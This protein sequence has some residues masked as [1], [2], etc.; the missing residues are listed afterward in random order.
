MSVALLDPDLFQAAGAVIVLL[1]GV[2]VAAACVERLRRDRH[3]AA[4]R[5]VDREQF[6]RRLEVETRA[7]QGRHE[8][9]AERATWEG[10]REFVVSRIA[11]HENPCGSV[12]SF[13]LESRDARPLP[14]FRPGQFLTLRLHVPGESRPVVRCYSLSEGPGAERFRFTV[15]RM[16]GGRASGFLHDQVHEGHVLEVKAPGGGFCI[17]TSEGHPLVLLAGGVGLTPLLS[18]L[19]ALERCGS[20]REAWL[21]YGARQGS[22][23]ILLHELLSLS[24]RPEVRLVLC[25]SAPTEADR[26]RWGDAEDVLLGRRLSVDLAQER[27]PSG[28][29]ETHEFYICGPLAMMS[30][31][32][33]GLL[34]WRVPEAHIHQEAFG[35]QAAVSQAHRADA[36]PTGV[37]PTI[38]FARAGKQVVWDPAAGSLLALA[39]QNGVFIEAGCC[40]GDCHTCQTPVTS[41]SVTYL[42]QPDEPAA[43]GC[44]LPCVA[45]PSTDLVLDA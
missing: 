26:L 19:H 35:A 37:Q 11:R 16:E 23:L 22:D 43:E 3:A 40:A 34:E 14:G 5:A 39:E 18:M 42:K 44:C 32:H 31:L 1:V 36:S 20:G 8:S 33:E 45:V 38:R 27:L 41:G 30:A 21:F 13:W 7:L 15:R 10:W 4:L 6:A 2:Y 24:R 17:D 28:S 9:S 25:L 29:R 12:A